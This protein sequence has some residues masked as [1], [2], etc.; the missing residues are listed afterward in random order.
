MAIDRNV[1]GPV[2]IRKEAAR[3]MR[4]L[5]RDVY[6]VLEHARVFRERVDPAWPPQD[7]PPDVTTGDDIRNWLQGI[8]QRLAKT[9]KMLCALCWYLLPKSGA[10]S[11]ESREGMHEDDAGDEADEG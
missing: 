4:I 2:A 7:W 3:A 8:D 10:G 11:L 5:E 1:A 9:E 6:E